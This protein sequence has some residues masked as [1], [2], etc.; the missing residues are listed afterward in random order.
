MNYARPELAE[1]LASEYVL[2]TLQGGA[3]RRFEVLLPAHPMLRQAVARWNERLQPLARALPPLAPS[4]AVWQGIEARLD[5]AVHPSQ[6]AASTPSRAA[7]PA[8][9]PKRPGFW[10]GLSFWRGWALGATT[11]A[12]VLAVVL[13]QPATVPPPLVVVLS[14]PEGASSFVAGVAADGR[15]MV[16]RPVVNVSTQADR[17]LELWA[18]PKEGAPRSLGLISP[19]KPTVLRRGRILEGTAAFAVSLEPPGGSPTGAPTGPILFSGK[20][21]L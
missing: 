15:S 21:Q 5:G 1:R 16:V 4:P 3:R 2:G 18:V 8:T 6:A 9:T 19:D 17:A 7:S 10:G 12:A 20:L 11:A 14:A 13:M